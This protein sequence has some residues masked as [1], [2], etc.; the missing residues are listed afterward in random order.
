MVL[1]DQALDIHRPQ[2]DLIAPGLAQAGR[3][4]RRPL[5]LRLRGW[6]FTKQFV[7]S[8][9]SL[10]NSAIVGNH[11]RPAI[12]YLRGKFTAY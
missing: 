2:F 3:A 6:K 5:G 8:H 11:D 12:R 10:G 4:L 9:S 7:L 1:P